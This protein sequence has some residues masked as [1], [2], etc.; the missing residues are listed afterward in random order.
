M[1]EISAKNQ[2][3]DIFAKHISDISTEYNYVKSY[4]IFNF[5]SKIAILAQTAILVKIA[6]STKN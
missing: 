5:L 1:T 2:T 4:E 3:S 6:I